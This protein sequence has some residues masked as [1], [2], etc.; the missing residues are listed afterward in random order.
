MTVS[1]PTLFSEALQHD[2]IAHIGVEA[3]TGLIPEEQHWPGGHFY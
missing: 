1:G 3:L 2:A